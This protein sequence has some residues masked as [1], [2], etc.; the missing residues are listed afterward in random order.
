M[1]PRVGF[2]LLLL[3]SAVCV[4]SQSY[5]IDWFTIDGGGGTST[6]GVY[7]VSGTMGQ[8]DATAT[9]MSGGNFSLTGGF[10]SVL[11][12]DQTPGAPLLTIR[13]TTTNTAVISW[14]SPSTGFNLEQNV[15][16]GMTN[17]TTPPEPVTDDGTNKFI[18]INPPGGER[19][20]RLYKP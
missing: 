15:N 13:L 5:S 19:F 7:S 10:W 11:G 14:P 6:G 18:I 3:I 9:P 20:Y 2:I 16:L 1:P 12:V 17:W 8:P 4:R